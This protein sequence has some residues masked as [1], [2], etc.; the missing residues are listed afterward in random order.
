MSEMEAEPI[1]Y[2]ITFGTYGTRLHGDPRGTVDRSHNR[3][4]QALVGFDAIRWEREYENLK[5]DPIVLT[6]EEMSQAENVIPEICVRG[7]WRH[8][9]SA[10]RSNHVHVLLTGTADGNA[11]RKWLNRWLGEAMCAKWSLPT[12]ASWWA[13]S[14]SVRW[15][16]TDEYFRCSLDYIERQR[17]TR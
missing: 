5:F 15:I 6:P 7:G 17:S 3:P 8:H 16:W 14:G 11:I 9:V 1:A 10:A 4:G 12:G 2:H 13:E